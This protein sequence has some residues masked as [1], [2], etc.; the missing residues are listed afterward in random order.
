MMWIFTMIGFFSVVQKS[1]DDDLTVRARAR[2]DL[3]ALRARHLPMMSA[4]IDHGGTDYPWR[5]K[6]SHADFAAALGQLAAAIDYANFKNTVAARQG[7]DRSKVYS[8]VW[9]ALT[10]LEALPAKRAPT[11]RSPRG[12]RAAFGG[13]V[14]DSQGRVLLREPRDHHGGYVWTFPKGRPDPGESP[15]AAALR[16]VREEIGV[17]AR[18]RTEIDTWFEGDTTDTRFFVMDLVEDHGELD[19]ETSQV[20]WVTLEEARD[21]VGVTRSR[22]GRTRDLAVLEAVADLVTRERSP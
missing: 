18:I 13:V 11:Q 17:T 3:E 4:P 7:Q 8:K 22:A 21:M 6:V 10:A 14:L 12:R 9:S 19:E 1:G 20:R 15:E 2:A 16:E 5:A